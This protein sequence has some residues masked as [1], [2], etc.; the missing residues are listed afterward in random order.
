MKRSGWLARLG[1]GAVAALCTLATVPAAHAQTAKTVRIGVGTR[2]VS[3]AYPWLTMPNALSY[4]KQEGLSVDVTAVGGSLEAV[5][6]LVSGNV[7]FVQINS[8]II[9][10]ANVTNNIPL[11]AVMLNTVND[12][13]IVVPEDGPVK[14][15]ADLKGK[16][17]GVPALS[18][19][20]MPLLL[21]LLQSQGLQADKDVDIIPVGYGPPAYQ[22]LKTDKVQGLMFFQAA[23]AGFENAGGKFRYFHG[24]DWRKQPD[25]ALVTLQKTIDQDPAMIEALVRGAAKASVFS[26]A[27]PDCVRREQ[28]AHWPDTKPSGSTDEAVLARW[29]MNNMSAQLNSMRDALALSGSKLWGRYTAEEAGVLQDFMLA[30]K[31]I[32]KTMPPATYVAAIPDLFEKANAFDP[33]P[34]VA[35]AKACKVG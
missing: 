26:M 3:D 34:V 11:R 1:V 31:Q 4:W 9:V 6:Q 28:W 29:D 30:S 14:T 17:I 23:I 25:F 16:A 8:A 35:D 24:D 13:S 21:T 7:D 12:W 2:V 20:G 18:T 19:G 27:N 5:Q 15:I 22:A 33:A 32:A 10:Q